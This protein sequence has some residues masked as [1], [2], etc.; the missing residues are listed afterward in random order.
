LP[1][2][3][4]CFWMFVIFIF[5]LLG[6]ISCT[7]EKEGATSN[8][9]PHHYPDI[10]TE[11]VTETTP[12]AD[13]EAPEDIPED[14]YEKDCL[15][16]IYY[17]CPP[18]DEMNRA[19][20]LV[21]ICDDNRVLSIS[22]CEEVLE[23]IPTPAVVA[24]EECEKD[25]MKG[26]LNVYCFKGFFEKGPCDP[27]DLEICDGIDNDCD[28]LTDEGKYDCKS[29]CGVGSAVCVGGE[30]VEC[31]A[32]KPE[33]EICDYL[34]NDC[35]G[36]IDEGLTNNCGECGKEPEEICDHLDN[37]CDGETDEGQLNDCGE[38][39]PDLDE[40]CDGI[41]N[42]CDGLID[43]ELVKECFTDCEKSLEYCIGGQ[44]VCTAKKPL[45]E[46]CNGLDDDCDGKVDEGLQ[47]L[48]TMQDLGVL[49][50]CKESPLI[51]GEGYKTCECIDKKCSKLQLTECFAV[52]HWLPQLLP[53]NAICDKL[54]G[55]SKPEECNNHDDNCNQ[56]VDE[57]LFGVCYSGPPETM[58]IGICEA[59]MLLCFEGKWGNYDDN[60]GFIKKLCLGEITPEPEDICN[61]TDANCD[62]KID[63]DKQLT[64]TDILFIVD[65]S[66]SMFEEINAVM[67]ALNKFATYYSDSEVVKWGLVFTASTGNSNS[68]WKERV[69][70][71]TNL[72]DF[73]TFISIFQNSGYSLD[74]GYEQNYDAIYLSIHNLVSQAALPYLVTDLKWIELGWGGAIGESIPPKEQWNISWRNDAKHVIILFSDE[75]GQSYLVPKITESI[76]VQMISVAIDLSIY[77]FSEKYILDGIWGDSYIPLIQAGAG[78]KAYELKT[79]AIEIYNNLLEILEETACSQQKTNSPSP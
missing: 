25:G 8:S 53:P 71:Q 29:E 40:I 52:C 55:I 60:N 73:K 38:C 21:D 22:D 37:D 19:K 63:E 64:P 58:G 3:K 35:D 27:C 57:N 16:E 10:T 50:P 70:L 69:V 67:T 56:L 33:V 43:E 44:W 47:C 74:G 49:M 59:G 4:K 68:S 32:P 61:G 46:I 15:R 13:V 24:V 78:G 23:C 51:C 77:V 12:S 5:F 6:A 36:E 11:D 54:M 39:G 18:L 41:D 14:T 45:P 20:A 28:G 42:D 62:G 48:C 72:V 7:E 30:I 2:V 17:Y 34:D 66:G 9:T 65:L 31:D 79:K 26:Y 1:T 75:E 76:L